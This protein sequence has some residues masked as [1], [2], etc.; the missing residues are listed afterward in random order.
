M[1]K[2]TKHI[3]TLAVTAVS[4]L[5]MT[6]CGSQRNAGTQGAAGSGA[7]AVTGQVA[8]G[9]A[10]TWQNVY[11]PVRVSVSAPK[12]M[13]MSGR[14][15][16]VRDSVIN[17]SMRVL[18]M[19]VAAVQITPDS[20]WVVDKF[21]KLVFSEGT[22]ALL[23]GRTMTVGQIQALLL[24]TD[25]VVAEGLSFDNGKGTSVQ[26]NFI[27]YVETPGGN[28]ATTVTVDATLPKNRIAC[29]LRWQTDQAIWNDPAR[30]VRFNTNFRGY[31][32]ITAQQAA[33]ILKEL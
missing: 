4:L 8:D 27:D 30:T 3:L 23:G 2:L 13:S 20:V 16:M 17:L 11:M 15:T 25:N 12:S 5:A 14:V 19:E 6:A 28:I 32:R 10:Q 9:R 24:G 31:Q 22:R 33:A 21:H 18:G 1:I 26:V 7:G 29:S